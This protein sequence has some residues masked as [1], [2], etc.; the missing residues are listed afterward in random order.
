MSQIV[1]KARQ[2]VK[3]LRT[4]LLKSTLSAMYG[5]NAI[6]DCTT[7]WHSTLD[8][9]ERL[10]QLKTYCEQIEDTDLKLSEIMWSKISALI[11]VLKPARVASKRLQGEQLLLGDLYEIWQRCIIETG[12]KK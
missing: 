9:L 4:P 12:K 11:E 10:F 8:M 7:R 6:L 5:K 2:I 1:E 3:K